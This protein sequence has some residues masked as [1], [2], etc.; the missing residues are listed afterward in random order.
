MIQQ[1]NHWH[2]RFGT[3]LRDY[4]TQ[5]RITSATLARQ[6]E[7]SGTYVLYWEQGLK[8]PPAHNSAIGQR[9][10][11]SVGM[12][13]SAYELFLWDLFTTSL[14]PEL[15]TFSR[16]LS[17]IFADA[18]QWPAPLYDVWA[19]VWCGEP[20]VVTKAPSAKESLHALTHP[21]EIRWIT[22]D[23]T[24]SKPDSEITDGGHV[25]WLMASCYALEFDFTRISH[26][27][28]DEV[29]EARSGDDGG[30]LEYETLLAASYA[31]RPTGSGTRQA[32]RLIGHLRWPVPESS[33]FKFLRG[34]THV[35]VDLMHAWDAP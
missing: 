10:Y 4:R 13:P 33:R 2:R 21:D 12:T 3:R 27:F 7:C 19:D 5:H 30:W 24:A 8:P 23:C 20:P 22:P 18:E 1:T 16:L 32:G 15:R 29:S 17:H 9:L 35:S 25:D 31:L 26:D 11:R 6:A 28:G 14:A 34:H